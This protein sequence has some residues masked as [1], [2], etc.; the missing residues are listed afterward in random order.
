MFY[1]YWKKFVE[2][3]NK[4]LYNKRI[5][6][7][8][9]GHLSWPLEKSMVNGIV[10][11]WMKLMTF[12]WN[13]ILTDLMYFWGIMKQIPRRLFDTHSTQFDHGWITVISQWEKNVTKIF[14]APVYYILLSIIPILWNFW[15]YQNVWKRK[16]FLHTNY[17]VT[18]NFIDF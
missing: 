18:K 12:W 14:P 17:N 9:R 7:N 16:L 10:L 2:E 4:V 1:R 11:I 3:N 13:F 15:N 8:F 5:I 6:C